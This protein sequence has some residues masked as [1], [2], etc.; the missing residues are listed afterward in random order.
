MLLKNSLQESQRRHAL[1]VIERSAES[2][3]ELIDNML[4]MSRIITGRLKLNASPV[5]IEQILL[6]AVDVIRPSAEA[7][8]IDL[9]S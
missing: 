5:E 2:Q 3:K 6:A 9:Q 1:D 7:K 8:R 4:D